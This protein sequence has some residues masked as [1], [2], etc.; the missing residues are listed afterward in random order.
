M[1][2][3]NVPADLRW[4][5]ENVSEWPS[6][7]KARSHGIGWNGHNDG[8]E[9]DYIR[10]VDPLSD[11]YTKP[12]WLQARQLLG[13]ED[14]KEGGGMW[15]DWI[16]WGG[17]ECPLP[18]GAMHEVQYRSGER[19]KDDLPESSYW[20]DDGDT[21]DIVAYRYRL[22]DNTSTPEEEEAF[23]ELEEKQNRQKYSAY[24]KDVRHLEYIDVYR[25]V[26]LFGCEKHGHAISHAAKKLLLT[27]VRT[28]G[29]DVEQ[30]VR[31]AID[32]LNRW[33]EMKREDASAL[34]AGELGE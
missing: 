13:L 14:K 17:G 30:E 27:G 23:R 29:K 19:A 18:D 20:G 3:D 10:R 28:G 11:E 8:R 31:E 25:T 6:K 24:F 1:N 15:S 12:Q 7:P 9:P 5:A 21:C 16:E 33:L 26:D 4:L 32:S 2:R 22:D 34:R